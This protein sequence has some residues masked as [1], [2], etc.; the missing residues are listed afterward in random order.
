MCVLSLLLCIDFVKK[1]L[2]Q[3]CLDSRRVWN[4]HNIVVGTVVS[5][6]LNISSDS[7]WNSF[8]KNIHFCVKTWSDYPTIQISQ[9]LTSGS[10]KKSALSVTKIYF[11]EFKTQINGWRVK[12]FNTQKYVWTNPFVIQTVI[13]EP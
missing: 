8:T 10:R 4:I 5:V 2:N 11:K 3:I 9:H 12:H 13:L 1:K 7:F 6:Y